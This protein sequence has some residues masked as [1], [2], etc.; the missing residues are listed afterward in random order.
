MTDNIPQESENDPLGSLPTNEE[1]LNSL[2]NDEEDISLTTFDKLNDATKILYA[3]W[4]GFIRK[5]PEPVLN[6][7]NA[8]IDKGVIISG[9]K[10]RNI[11]ADRIKDEKINIPNKLVFRAYVVMRQHDNA[12]ATQRKNKITKAVELAESVNDPS[13]PPIPR[14]I[15][16]DLTLSVENKK[17]RLEN[18]VKT[19][20][21][22]ITIIKEI[23]KYDP[24]ASYETALIALGKEIRQTTETLIK[25]REDLKSEGEKDVE[26]YINL[27]LATIL[28]AA[29]QA[30]VTI[31]GPDKVELFKTSLKLKLKDNNLEEV[32]ADKL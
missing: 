26:R 11:A 30:Y 22:R 6:E 19:C 21:Q 28:R 17:E 25:M 5:L 12:I 15:Y 3:R 18:W 1:F 2:G 29:I 9:E 7:L 32:P 8:L 10:L 14:S 31:H 16:E 20:E 4:A 27:K 24:S 13:K 23:Q